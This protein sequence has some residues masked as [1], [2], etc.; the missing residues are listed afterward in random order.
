M[1]NSVNVNINVEEIRQ[2]A[3]PHLAFF[4]HLVFGIWWWRGGSL[5]EPFIAGAAVAI[6]KMRC[7]GRVLH[8]TSRLYHTVRSLQDLGLQPS[9]YKS[10]RDLHLVI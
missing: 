7:Y 8:G 6:A 9:M 3:R 4:H 10:R 2:S 5:L 1:T